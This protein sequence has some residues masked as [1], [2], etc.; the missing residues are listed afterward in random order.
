MPIQLT[1]AMKQ[2]INKAMDEGKFITVAY[3]DG[4]GAPHLSYRGSVIAYGDDRLALWVRNPQGGL[5]AAL[6]K[7]PQMGFFYANFPNRMFFTING[8]ASVA[9]SAKDADAIYAAIPQGERDK[10]PERKGAPLII[11]IDSVSGMAGGPVN[12]RR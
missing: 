1:D 9:A 5:L 2:G 3:V 10:D 6:K 4:D 8:R 7:N 12:M 11:E